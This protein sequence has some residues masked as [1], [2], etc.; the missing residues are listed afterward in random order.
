MARRGRPRKSGKRTNADRLSRAGAIL[1]F[2]HGTEHAKAMQ[3]LYGNDGCDAVGRA[4]RAGLLGEGSEAKALLDTARRIANA[5]WIAYSTGRY[6]C[7]LADRTHG[8]GVENPEQVRN[9]EVWLSA[10]LKS[11]NGSRRAFD[12][13]VID[14][15]PDHGPQW[16]DQVIA[17]KRRNAEPT[18]SHWQTFSAAFDALRS[19]TA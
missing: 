1:P 16:L 17:D 13:L 12:G 8:P 10:S 19:L 3:V 5:Y 4:Y 7:P 9:R 2:D 15:H 14:V 18:G 11:V 6:Q